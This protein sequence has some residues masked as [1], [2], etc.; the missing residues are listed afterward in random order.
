MW[1]VNLE[2]VDGAQ[3]AI[4]QFENGLPAFSYLSVFLHTLGLPW[5]LGCADMQVFVDAVEF[6]GV[7]FNR[8][9]IGKVRYSKEV[10]GLNVDSSSN[11]RR[12]I[13]RQAKVRKRILDNRKERDKNRREAGQVYADNGSP[14]Y[15]S[16][17]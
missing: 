8:M 7:D 16:V 10:F 14:E 3:H 13:E 11:L 6:R 4:L 1:R 17:R 2:V 5:Q 9:V 12:L 15:R